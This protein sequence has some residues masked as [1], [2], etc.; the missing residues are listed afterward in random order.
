MVL[1]IVKNNTQEKM[2]FKNEE[3]NLRPLDSTLQCS[4]TEP[5]RLYSERGLLQ[6]SYDM[7]PAHF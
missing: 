5:Q 2:S 1:I 7:H 3:S 6:S 4:T